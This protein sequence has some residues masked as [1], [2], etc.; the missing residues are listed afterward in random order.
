MKQNVIK[1]L[2]NLMAAAV[3]GFLLFLSFPKYGSGVVAWLAL[4]PLFFALRGAKP[5]EGFKIGFLTGLIAHIGILYWIVYVVVQYGYLPIYVGVAVMLLLAAYLS[6]YTACIAMGIV[7]LRERGIPFVLSAPLLWTILEYTR[8]HLLTGFPWE[9]LAYSQYLHHNII[10]ISDITGTY[11][12]SFVILLINVILYDLLSTRYQKKFLV[13]EAT[14]AC[15]VITSIVSYG[16]YRVEAIRG[17]LKEAPRLDVSLIQGNIDQN[18]K[19]N[20]LYQAQTIDIYRSLSVKSVGPG[21]GLIVWPET[22]APFYFQQQNRMQEAIVDIARTTRSAL[23]FG[24]PSYERE[25]GSTSY[26]NSAFLLKSDGTL[27]GRYDKVHLVPYGEYV[28]LRSYFPFIGK[29]VAGVGDFK[30]G[31]GFYPL[32]VDGHRLGVLICYEGIFPEAAGDYKRKGAELLVNITNDAWFGKTSAPTQHLSMTAFRAVENRLYLVRAANTGISAII[33]PTGKIVSRTGLFQR[34]VL[35]GEVKII[36]EKT[37][38]AAYGDL[39]VYGCTL[40][41]A[42]VYILSKQRRK[43]HAGRNS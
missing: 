14:I 5:K 33:D 35:R 22:A 40:A 1:Y 19:W 8:S 16:H 6:L 3:S 15:I 36:D 41:L 25:G 2:K 42:L 11:G 34:A 21:G 43:K 28:P 12:I 4:I 24:S 13:A 7:F 29:L 18:L 17:L 32:S 39:F 27:I 26:M 37:Y 23:L 31:K 20:S 10:Q 30:P 9:N 38:Y